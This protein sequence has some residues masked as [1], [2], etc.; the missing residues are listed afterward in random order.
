MVEVLEDSMSFEDYSSLS[1]AQR[2]KRHKHKKAALKKEEKRK[3]REE[4]E[5]REEMVAAEKQ[6]RGDILVNGEEVVEGGKE[7]EQVT[8]AV[9]EVTE[10][11]TVV[12]GNGR[13]DMVVE[14]VMATEERI[15]SGSLISATPSPSSSLTASTQQ[16]PTPQTP[17]E[18]S[19]SDSTDITSPHPV[20]PLSRSPTSASVVRS[21]SRL[22][23]VFTPAPDAAALAPS[24]SYFARLQAHRQSHI[25]DEFAERMRTAAIMLAQLQQQPYRGTAT[26]PTNP[27]ASSLPPGAAATAL[28]KQPH[29]TP[30]SRAETDEIRQRIIKEMMA[31]EEHRMMKMKT[32]GV[33]SG[34][35]GSGGEG[36][37]GVMLE[38]EKRVREFVDKEDPSGESVVCWSFIMFHGREK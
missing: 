34:V 29:L 17:A 16:S 36:G 19:P 20:K 30:K 15:F 4:K 11:E 31:L 24:D 27:A 38:D 37:G 25:A 26:A 6:V 13:G 8:A 32:E 35:G 14:S 28:G 10:A 21:P 23:T 5:E 3:E 18:P 7:K 1:L 12:N 33:G 2:K 22:S 9:I